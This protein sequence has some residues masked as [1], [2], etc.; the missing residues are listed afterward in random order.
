[1]SPQKDTSTIVSTIIES[2]TV[3]SD[4]SVTT[5]PSSGT[6]IVPTQS[7]FSSGTV[8]GSTTEID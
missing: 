2:V 1:M 6:I 4:I 5:T 7:V 8:T 3:T